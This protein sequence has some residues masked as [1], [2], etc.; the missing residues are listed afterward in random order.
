M[1]EN[2]YQF[3]KQ[4]IKGNTLI[5]AF[6]QKEFIEHSYARYCFSCWEI[7]QWTKQSS[8]SYGAYI[9]VIVRKNHKEISKGR[10]Q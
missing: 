5:N 4:K 1:S 10:M 9:A 7:Q 8:Y 2:I 3:V 6:N